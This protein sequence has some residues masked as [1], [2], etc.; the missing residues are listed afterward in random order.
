MAEQESDFPERMTLNGADYFLFQLD[1][2]MWKLGKQRNICTFA[3]TLQERISA[4]ELKKRLTANLSYQ[5]ICRLRLQ[6]SW[7]FTLLKWVH[8]SAIVLA[9]IQQYQ[10]E[11]AGTLPEHVFNMP[12]DVLKDPAF[13]VTLLQVAG[14]AGSIIIFT[15]HHALMDAR[16]GETFIRHLGGL[17]D[18][19]QENLLS[20][21]QDSLLPLRD[22]ANIALQMKEFLCE[23]SKLPIFSLAK[24]SKLASPLRYRVLAYS[25]QQHEMIKARANE[26]GAGFLVSAFYLA[27]TACAIASVQQQKGMQGEKDMLI[28]IP[29]DRRKRGVDGP[30]MGNQVTFLFYRIPYAVLDNVK[31]CM[32]ELIEQMKL[33]MRS[34]NPKHFLVMMTFLRRVPGWLYLMQLTSP[35]KG[36]MASFYYSDTGDSL[37]VFDT[38]FGSAVTNV[39]H[40]PPNMYPPGLTFVFSRYQGVLQITFAY[41]ESVINAAEV[42]VLIQQMNSGLLG[43]RQG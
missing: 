13:R 2:L 40:Y 30:V 20:T 38:L 10:L 43:E 37:D 25:T 42:E 26:Q 8:K 19:R 34:E 21:E 41:R 9:E 29:L 33:L 5:W 23:I 12:F 3:V 18:L 36:Q 4:E 7:P 27:A 1:R 31:N 6:K 11:D 17:N 35:T 16:G 32:M 24:T 22:Q 28:P 15:W 39:I 14:G